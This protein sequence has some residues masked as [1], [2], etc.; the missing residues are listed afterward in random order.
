MWPLA[1]ILAAAV[2]HRR[3]RRVSH[4]GRA[5]AARGLRVELVHPRRVLLP[6]DPVRHQLPA[7][8]PGGPRQHGRPGLL[9]AQRDGHVVHPARAR[10]QLLRDPAA[11]RPARLL[12]R[13][14]R[15]RL[16][17]QSALLSAD[18]RASLHLQ[19]GGVVAADHGH[20]LQ[21]GHDGAGVG[22]DGELA[23]DLQGR[24]RRGAPELC[25]AVLR[26]RA[27]RVR[28]LLDAGHD[29]GLP[30]RQHLL[31]LHELH[32]GSL[33]RRPCT[34][35]SRSSPGAPSTGWCRA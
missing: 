4:G 25:A 29:R 9:H 13:P 14:R 2:A 12:L 6:P 26:D 19:P 24:G 28:P 20:P 27:D 35:S 8:L 1:V 10:R 22:G 31:A 7:V 5:S 3:I 16:L 30:H 17:D 11:A 32:R 23:P 18:R 15:P 33:A 34:G 21:R